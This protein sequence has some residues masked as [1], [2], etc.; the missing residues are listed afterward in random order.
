VDRGPENGRV[1]EE[2][3][4]EVAEKHVT[5]RNGRPSTKRTSMK[6]TVNVDDSDIPF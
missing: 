1:D 5:S 6:E 3:E 4:E 2:V